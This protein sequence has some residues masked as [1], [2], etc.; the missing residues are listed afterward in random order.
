MDGEQGATKATLIPTMALSS[1]VRK[2]ET[3]GKGSVAISR[4]NLSTFIS[5]NILAGYDRKLEENT[6][7]REER[8][9]SSV[10]FLTTLVKPGTPAWSKL[11]NGL[12]AAIMDGV[13]H[14]TLKRRDSGFY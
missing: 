10:P 9:F 3:T 5:T 13:L 8:N 12:P 7:W 4:A 14:F 1:S 11:G 2:C 6:C